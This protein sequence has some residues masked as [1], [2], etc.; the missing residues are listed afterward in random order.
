LECSVQWTRTVCSWSKSCAVSVHKFKLDAIGYF[1]HISVIF[2][3]FSKRSVYYSSVVSVWA[4][5]HKRCGTTSS[6]S[7]HF[8]ILKSLCSLHE[9]TVF[10]APAVF[11]LKCCFSETSVNSGFTACGE[12]LKD[13][14]W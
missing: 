8:S 13:R 2:A 10:R 6:I 12:I 5:A 7:Q 14:K 4:S 3:S 1:R 11:R 9:G